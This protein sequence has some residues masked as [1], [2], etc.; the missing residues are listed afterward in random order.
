MRLILFSLPCI[1]LAA[2][3][4][5]GLF[6]HGEASSSLVDSRAAAIMAK[7][8]TKHLQYE[9]TRLSSRGPGQ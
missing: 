6:R 5:Q 9:R 8:K 3:L 7:V 1:A 4:T 2:V